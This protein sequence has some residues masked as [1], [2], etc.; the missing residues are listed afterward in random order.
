MWYEKLGSIVIKSNSCRMHSVERIKV[1][2]SSKACGHGV[3]DSIESIFAYFLVYSVRRRDGCR[4]YNG[5]V[6][7]GDHA[8]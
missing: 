1:G 5:A 2:S 7:D 8:H 3:I 6:R 4:E